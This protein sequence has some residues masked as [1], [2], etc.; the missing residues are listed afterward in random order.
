MTVCRRLRGR[1]GGSHVASEWA[2]TGGI[3]PPV[4]QAERNA[5]RESV[6]AAAVEIA[7]LEIRLKELEGIR[8]EALAQAPSSA[9]AE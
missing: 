5:L 3:V 2:L 6:Q 8:V 7:A 1:E 4:P 9:A